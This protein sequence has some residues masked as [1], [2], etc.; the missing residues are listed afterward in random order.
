MKNPYVAF[1][2]NNAWAN[3]TLYGAL[4]RLSE[5]EFTAAAPGFFPSLAATLNHIHEVDLYYIDAL[6]EGGLGRSVYDREDIDDAA[7]LGAAQAASDARLLAFCMG[8]TDAD[9]DR[10][11]RP[12]GGTARR[13]RPSATCF[14]ICSSTRCTIAGRPMCSFSMRV[15]TRRNSTTSSSNTGACPV[16][17]NTRASGWTR[18]GHDDRL[19][20]CRTALHPAARA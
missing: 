16:P 3:R 17:G 1:A 13:P 8:L 20:L 5:P 19:R 4:T 14:R 18:G 9:L 7:E 15:S 6:T 11:V 10:R 12:S 2:S